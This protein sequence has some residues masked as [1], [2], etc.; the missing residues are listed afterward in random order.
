MKSYHLVL[1]T[2]DSSCP[3][4]RRGNGQDCRRAL[5]QLYFLTS[6]VFCTR[7][8][9]LSTT[10]FCI[11]LLLCAVTVAE[12]RPLASA[13]QM[14]DLPFGRSFQL[15][16][17]LFALMLMH[18]RQQNAWVLLSQ[19]NLTFDCSYLVSSWPTRGTCACSGKE[20]NNFFSPI[21]SVCFLSH[22]TLK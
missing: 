1:V 8:A 14:L 10:R 19:L 5:F 21:V 17:L 20:G 11:C 22:L 16:H 4:N 12:S 15:Q 13:G 18:I 9:I 2:D 6:S 7:V 3:A